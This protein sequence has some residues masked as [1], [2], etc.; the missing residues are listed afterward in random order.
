MEDLKSSI[1]SI[2]SLSTTLSA[3]LEYILGDYTR[4]SLHGVTYSNSMIS[5][6]RKETL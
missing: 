5:Y 1:W 3:I 2:L 6:N 4:G